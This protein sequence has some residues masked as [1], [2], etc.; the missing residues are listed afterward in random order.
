MNILTRGIGNKAGGAVKQSVGS[1]GRLRTSFGYNSGKLANSWGYTLAGSYKKGNGF[2]DETWSEGYFYYA[3]IQ[4]EIR[5][6]ILSLS[7][8][9]AP[10]KHGQRKYK[11]RISV[12][13]TTIA[14]SLGDTSDFIGKIINKGIQYNEHWGHLDRWTLDNN[15]DTLHNR[16]TLNTRQNY[17]HKPQFSLRDF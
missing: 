14:R 8:M 12:F 1:F 9:G 16:E 3:K 6:H 17:Y 15:G 4:K 13:D 11:N 10:Q 7:V 2:V 5:N